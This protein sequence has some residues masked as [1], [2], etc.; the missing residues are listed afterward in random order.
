MAKTM[1]EVQ[2]LISD[3][4]G[5]PTKLRVAMAEMAIAIRSTE[6]Q[7]AKAKYE[8]D[9]KTIAIAL[10]A[11][12]QERIYDV[13]LQARELG[14]TSLA[15]MAALT[16]GKLS[17]LDIGLARANP[18]VGRV[19]TGTTGLPKLPEP[20]EGQAMKV[21]DTVYAHGNDDDRAEYASFQ[22]SDKNASFKGR[23]TLL[24]RM[25]SAGRLAP[26]DIIYGPNKAKA[27]S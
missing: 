2:K 4:G 25:I 13:L 1:L 10:G 26:A 7:I 18:S 27:A 22:G 5:D 11:D 24:R 14:Y 23:E 19:A 3:A 6:D 16:D 20:P 8:T 17:G 21:K 9:T 12:T 15:F